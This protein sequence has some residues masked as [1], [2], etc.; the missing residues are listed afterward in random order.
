MRERDQQQSHVTEAQASHWKVILVVA[1]ENGEASANQTVPGM[2]GALPQS[3][4]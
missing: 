3:C 4:R 2:A 1:S